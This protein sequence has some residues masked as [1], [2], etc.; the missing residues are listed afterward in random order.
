[1]I[2]NSFKIVDKSIYSGNSYSRVLTVS[3][4]VGTRVRIHTRMYTLV[5]HVD[6]RTRKHT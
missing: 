6:G 4:F 2:S 1:M 3:G 5:G